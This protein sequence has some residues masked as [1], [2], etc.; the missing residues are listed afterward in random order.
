MLLLGVIAGLLAG[1]GVGGRLDRLSRIRLRWTA[2]IVGALLLASL[3]HAGIEHDVEQV[4]QSRLPLY[5]VAFGLL[6]AALWANRRSP[7]MLIAGVGVAANGLA[8]IAN[9][10]WMPV[11]GPALGAA[12]LAPPDIQGS[13]QSVLPDP[14]GLDFLL[15]AGPL[16]DIIPFPVP[17]LAT[18]ASIGDVFLS[19]GLAWFVFTTLA[20]R[21][22]AGADALDAGPVA[23]RAVDADAPP[24][25]R[26]R[27]HAFVRLAMDARFSAFWL[28]QTISMFGDRLHQVALGVLVYAATGSP[29]A[30]GLVF[31]AATLPNLLLGPIAGTFVDRWDHKRLMVASD[32]V[33]AA[34]V[35]VLPF[36]ASLDIVLVYPLV[37]LVTTVSIFFRPA[38]AAV[39]PR[40]VHPDDLLAANSATWTGETLADIVGYPLAGVFVAFLGQALSIAFFA[41]AATYVISGLLILAV[42]IPPVVRETTMRTAG[43]ARTFASELVA[44]WRFLRSQPALYQNTVISALAQTSVGVTTALSIVYARDW[45]DVSLIPYPQDYAALQAAIGVGNLVGG[46]AVGVVGARIRRGSLVIGGMATMGLA[47]LIMGLTTNVGVAIGAATVLGVANL[48]YIIPTQTLFGEIVPPPLMGRVVAFRSS[49]VFGAMTAA[50]ALASVLAEHVPVGIVIAGFGAVTAVTAIVGAMLP[51]V[52][53]PSGPSARSRMGGTAG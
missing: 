37:F 19:L 28:G 14:L 25:V 39:V 24:P 16:A 1:L 34:L 2:V 41:D 20:R 26:A 45:L 48:V 50:M 8:V 49:L 7:G 4:G 47:T 6:T 27:R 3:T 12:G 13:F 23:V 52:R 40:I 43:A 32:L 15:R 36:A 9:G 44:G 33:R 38:K 11:W 42:S 22:A 21:P 46:F 10:G 51:A 53:D 5:G 35:V 30:T 31:L 18:V 29:L 17:P